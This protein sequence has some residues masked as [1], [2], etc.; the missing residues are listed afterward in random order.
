[1]HSHGALDLIRRA[2]KMLASATQK[3]L[4]LP[5]DL[6]NSAALN[7]M[8]FEAGGVS[9]KRARLVAAMHAAFR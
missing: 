2:T 5:T 1:M 6:K 3:L 9:F 8:R 7:A 4:H